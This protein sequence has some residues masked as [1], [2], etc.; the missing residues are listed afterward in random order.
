MGDSDQVTLPASASVSPSVRPFWTVRLE[1]MCPGAMVEVGV[2]MV[3][4]A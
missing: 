4:W 1:E 3:E 2:M